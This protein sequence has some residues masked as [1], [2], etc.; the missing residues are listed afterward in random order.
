M[1]KTKMTSLL[2]GALMNH[3]VSC[4]CDSLEDHL[5]K[6]ALDQEC[7]IQRDRHYV[8]FQEGRVLFGTELTKLKSD[9]D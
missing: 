5:T 9:N 1:V 6:V 8:E 3:R 2:N 7:I 4:I